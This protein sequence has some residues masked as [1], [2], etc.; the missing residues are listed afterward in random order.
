MA[1]TKADYGP[2]TP[3]TSIL[4]N[5]PPP[6][7]AQERPSFDQRKPQGDKLLLAPPASSR[8]H[9]LQQH[10]E[11][12]SHGWQTSATAYNQPAPLLPR[13]FKED[14]SLTRSWLDVRCEEE[15]TRQE[16]ER[17]QQEKLRLEQRRT[18]LVILR[19]SLQGGVPPTDVPALFL[20]SGTAGGSWGLSRA[21]PERVPDS[22]GLSSGTSVGPEGQYNT[23]P[24]S[25]TGSNPHQQRERVE[26]KAPLKPSPSIYFHHW[27]PPLA[28]SGSPK[29]VEQRPTWLP[30]EIDRGLKE[31]AGKYSANHNQRSHSLT[32]SSTAQNSAPS[33]G[34]FVPTSLMKSDTQVA[35]QSSSSSAT[36]PASYISDSLSN[37][38]EE[39]RWLEEK[40]AVMVDSVMSSIQRWLDTWQKRR[41]HDD[42]PLVQRSQPPPAET[43][44]DGESV[45]ANGGGATNPRGHTSGK[46]PYA[47]SCVGRGDATR[48]RK[49][50]GGQEE[51]GREGQN[52]GDDGRQSDGEPAEAKRR[53]AGQRKLACPF[54]KHN[55]S[56][57]REW[58]SCPGPGWWDAHRVKLV[59]RRTLRLA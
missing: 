48:K 49:A 6:S 19:T 26:A 57:Y 37:V 31:K 8:G 44:R 42:G 5:T 10:R 38:S 17:T 52:D 39:T 14:G 46:A 25:I 54:F 47:A 51:S 36:S 3:A 22:T 41:Q 45:N 32:I 20:R 27:Q 21:V 13:S 4:G 12:S 7:F 35:S 29:P 9:L 34:G 56:K 18:D 2:P 24:L 59:L 16:R 58:R 23:P 40:K 43:P 30:A 11:P 15:R 28:E 50:V 55:P 1:A 53:K 33:Q